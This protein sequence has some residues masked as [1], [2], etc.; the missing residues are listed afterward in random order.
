MIS[1]NQD[2][3][4]G[5][6][7]VNF[8]QDISGADS[9]KMTVEPREGAPARLVSGVELGK[10]DVDVGDETFLANEYLEHTTVAD[11]F[12]EYLGLWRARGSALY[13]AE[14]RVNNYETFRVS[15]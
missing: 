3:H 9:Y 13:V 12:K 11:E 5:K 15:L 2:A 14:N 10:V 8:N 7:R 6:L 1:F 4:G